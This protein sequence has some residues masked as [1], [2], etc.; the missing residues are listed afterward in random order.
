MTHTEKNGKPKIVRECS[1][2][3]T[4][5]ACVDL[6]VTDLAVIEVTGNGLLLRELAPGWTVEEV[7]AITE[8][9]LLVSQELREVEL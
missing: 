9:T 6:L 8:P 2:A 4:A 1:Y 5:R 3:L 7:Q